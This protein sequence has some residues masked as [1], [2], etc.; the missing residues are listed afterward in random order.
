MKLDAMEGAA[1]A[2]AAVA[3][4]TIDNVRAFWNDHP[5]GAWRVKEAFG[6][7]EFYE[8]YRRYRYWKQWHIPRLVPFERFAGKDVLEIGCGLGA[9]GVRFAQAGARYTGVDLSDVAVDATRLHFEA[10]GLT[11][12]FLMQNAEELSGLSDESFDLVYSHGVLHHTPDLSAALRQI[13]LV[14]RPGGEIIL[15]LYHKHSF[16]YYVRILGYQR[17][18]ALAY[19][20]MRRLLPSG[21][22]TPKLEEHYK[23]YGR[24]GAR[25]FGSDQFPHHCADGV[26]CPIAYSFSRA[27]VRRLLA[28]RFEQ[29]RFSVAHLPVRETLP[30]IPRGVEGAFASRI[31]WYLFIY[32]RRSG[33]AATG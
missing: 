5:C 22:R 12:R 18:Q 30:F 23:N 13:H 19:V 15:M 11:G 27:E 28:G 25:Y 2:S 1:G 7:P 20:A 31:G 3:D 16:N 29:I 10:Q 4:R 26:T 8:A 14:L 24:M 17:A 9:E 32:G 33:S 21:L 6:T